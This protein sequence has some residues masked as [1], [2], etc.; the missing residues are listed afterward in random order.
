MTQPHNDTNK[1]GWMPP[2]NDDT[3]EHLPLTAPHSD[4]TGGRLPPKDPPHGGISTSGILPPGG[5]PLLGGK[6]LATERCAG[7][8]GVVYKCVKR[9]TGQVVALKTVLSDGPMTEDEIKSMRRNYDRVHALSHDHIVRVNALEVDE[10]SGQ[11]YV[12]M[13]WVE[14]ESME[15][16]YRQF[17]GD[18]LLV[19]RDTIQVLRQIAQALDYA[20]GRGV[21]HRDVKD[22][23]IMIDKTGRTV[24]IDF[25]IASRAPHAVA[26][27]GTLP[28]AVTATTTV[29]TFAGTR[30]YQSPEQWRGERAEGASDEY[31]LAVTAYRSLSG[32]LPFWSANEGELQEMVLNDNMPPIKSL[33][34]E[35]NAVL[36]KA[37]AKLPSER[38]NSCSA[39]IDELEK[40]LSSLEGNANN[41]M[42]RSGIEKDM[43][44]S[45]P[46][47]YI[48]ATKVE[49][50][51][52]KTEKREWNRGQ[53]FGEHLDMMATICKSAK[54]AMSN[55][56]YP[57]AYSLYKQAD[58]EWQWL[59]MNDP[60]RKSAAATRKK[61]L[62]ARDSAEKA[63][64]GRLAEAEFQSAMNCLNTAQE[65]FES[66]R[67]EDSEKGFSETEGAFENATKIA[68]VVRKSRHIEDLEKSIQQAIDTKRLQDARR[69]VNE[70]KKLDP[71]KAI[72]WEKAINEAVVTKRIEDLEKS[73]KEAINAHRFQDA[74]RDVNE[75]K[76]LDA[77]KATALES[78]IESTETAWQ[79]ECIEAYEKFIREAIAT[80][81]FQDARQA[82][83]ELNKLDAA[84]ATPWEKAINEAVATKRLEDLRKSIKEAIDAQRFQDARQDIDELKKLDA[85]EAETL[86]SAVENAETTWRKERIELLEKT[87][88]EAIAVKR[89][90]VAKQAI[91]ELKK[92]NIAKATTWEAKIAT[93]ETQVARKTKRQLLIGITSIVVIFAVLLAVLNFKIFHQTNNFPKTN[94][95]IAPIP[96]AA[97][98]E[99][100]PAAITEKTAPPIES[101]PP[102]NKP[103]ILENG[104][105]YVVTLKP[106]VNLK[107]IKIAAGSFM[108]GSNEGYTDD[109]P[110]HRVRLTQDFWLGETEVTQ[111]QYEAIMDNNPSYN[112]KGGKYPVEKVS[113]YNAMSFCEKLTEK[114]HLAGRMQ[115]WKFTLPTDAQWEYACRSGTTTAYHFGDSIDESKANYRPDTKQKS[116]DQI[117]TTKEVGNYKPNQWGLYDMHGNVCEWC[118]DSWGMYRNR[119]EDPVAL[120]IGLMNNVGRAIRGGSWKHLSIHCRSA[121]R[122]FCI[123]AGTIEYLGFRIAMVP[124]QLNESILQKE[125]SS[126]R[127]ELKPTVAENREM[128]IVTLKSGVD[129][130]FVK[131][132]AGSFMMGSNDGE[133]IEKPIHKVS[134]TTDFWL[135]VYE[136]TQEQYETVMKDNPLY[137][138]KGEK[139]SNNPSYNNEGGNYPVEHVSWS[140]AILF[141]EILTEQ[142]HAA[143]RLKGWMFTLPTEA[144]WEYAC[145]AST[146]TTYNFGDY[147]D[148][149]KANYDHDDTGLERMDKKNTTRE[150]GSYAPNQWGLYD[151]HGNVW[152]WCLDEI[153]KYQNQEEAN[154]VG[155]KDYWHRVI[156][157][158]SWL[159]EAAHC[160]SACR[161]SVN[162]SKHHPALGF[163]L[164]LVPVQ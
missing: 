93:V 83:G 54:M 44:F 78:T 99:D 30:G 42:K 65:F 163:R 3:S 151:M 149:S 69:D 38:Y 5:L 148:K 86:E 33:P 138:D 63:D 24:L 28:H 82:V 49:D 73:F 95:V 100:F 37:L 102:K 62:A 79:K 50:H 114:E 144:Q 51:L 41:G 72:P 156:R 130:K 136:V 25:G 105:N 146:T 59:E 77:A 124:I 53:T 32:H 98:R 108:M 13:D 68:E 127:E 2:H 157:G 6:Y 31:S 84:K 15:G 88:H 129:I 45:M 36:K 103:I 46:E 75:L 153:R 66:G 19:A 55:K 7:G 52:A 154:P 104:D 1:T 143:G 61:A 70:L 122:N 164:A 94:Q 39:F 81:R 29:S 87:I 112:A 27:N 139:I 107:L 113:W 17:G 4:D 35:T 56:D 76:Q 160:R 120:P 152:E 97:Q 147:I 150:A 16:R 26:A 110:V 57:T 158:G 132:T 140:D 134:L 90:Q 142:E 74:R 60:R 159:D 101:I 12:E 133:I 89:F 43:S 118:L 145:R 85:A 111:E 64:V 161:N 91:N 119:E 106:G 8:M 125:K 121:S 137:N 21:I 23:N 14:G 123:P 128:Y 20:H 135:G 58:D 109:M 116:S 34:E 141:C 117:D 71:T 22:A 11:W 9:A 115:G 92:L 155:F 131:I 18:M 67:F 48:L 80:K 96:A 162:I 126:I 47:F 10:S 40:G